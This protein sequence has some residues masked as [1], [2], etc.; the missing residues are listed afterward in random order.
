MKHHPGTA[1]G[2]MRPTY[3]DYVLIPVFLDALHMI[4]KS[5]LHQK[6][7]SQQHIVLDLLQKWKVLKEPRVKTLLPSICNHHRFCPKHDLLLLFSEENLLIISFDL[8]NILHRVH[9]DVSVVHQLD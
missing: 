4:L 3:Y 9:Y 2:R 5:I 1:E 8:A 6:L 7:V